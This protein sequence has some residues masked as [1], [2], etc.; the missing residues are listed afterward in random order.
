MS[1]TRFGL[2]LFVVGIPSAV[3]IGA[4]AATFNDGPFVPTLVVFALAT[5]PATWGLGLVVLSDIPPPEYGAETIEHTWMTRAA[6]GAF[7]DVV[8]ALGVLVTVVIVL[9]LE[10]SADLSLL[11]VLILAM[12]DVAGRYWILRRRE[13]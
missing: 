10:I 13:S 3:G 11:A 9:D 1:K 12:V 5:L 6:T 8:T 7:L 4:L 2:T